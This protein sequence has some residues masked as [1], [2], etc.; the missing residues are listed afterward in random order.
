[1]HKLIRLLLIA[2][3]LTLPFTATKTVVVNDDVGYHLQIDQPD[4]A[5]DVVVE[6]VAVDNDVGVTNDVFIIINNQYDDFGILPA[7]RSWHRSLEQ[8][9]TDDR[10]P[11]ALN[12]TISSQ[13]H[14]AITNKHIREILLC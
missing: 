8:L 7:D 9:V 3:I 11:G 1:M 14:R 2:V 4:A 10:P 6:A 5:L 13:R 12:E